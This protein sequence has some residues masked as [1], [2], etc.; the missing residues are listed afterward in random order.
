MKRKLVIG[1]VVVIAVIAA[2]K[3]AG[4]VQERLDRQARIREAE[5]VT[6]PK[7][8][9]RPSSSSAAAQPAIPEQPRDEVNWDVPFTPQAP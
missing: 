7:P 2:W 3:G 8:E 6:V 9:P 1:I 5:E 4:S